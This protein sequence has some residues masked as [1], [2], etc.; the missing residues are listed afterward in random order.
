MSVAG[1]DAEAVEGWAADAGFERTE[2]LVHGVGGG[3]G[4]RGGGAGGGAP[5]AALLVFVLAW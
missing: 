5:V 2:R 1:T 4:G 3:G